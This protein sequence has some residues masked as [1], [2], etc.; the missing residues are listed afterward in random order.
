M[1]TKH[2][3]IE[4]CV[5]A[6]RHFIYG[7]NVDGVYWRRDNNYY[8]K[9]WYPAGMYWNGILKIIIITKNQ[10]MSDVYN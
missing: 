5:P 8:N 4:I 10:I 3:V 1:R 7:Q 9:I 2:E 6:A